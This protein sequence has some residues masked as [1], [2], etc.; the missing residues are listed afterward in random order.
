VHAAEALVLLA[1]MPTP[2]SLR[3]L[4]AALLVAGVPAEE[5]IW[6]LLDDYYNFLATLAARVTSREFSHFASLLDIGAV[7][8]VTLQNLLLGHDEGKM[9]QRLLAGGLSEGLMV[10][11]SRQY[12]RAWEGEMAAVYAMAAWRLFRELWQVSAA[13]RPELD[14]TERRRLVDEMIAPLLA[15]ELDGGR[16]AALAIRLYQLLLLARLRRLLPEEA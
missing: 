4:Q 13:M 10:L 6:P 16:R 3:R 8:G 12:V 15:G 5:P 11:A 2:A 9:W 1:A 14:A 7:G